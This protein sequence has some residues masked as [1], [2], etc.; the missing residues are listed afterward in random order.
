MQYPDDQN[1]E[2]GNNEDAGVSQDWTPNVQTP[3]GR[4][5]SPERQAGGEYQAG[6]GYEG[7]EGAGYAGQQGDVSE[8]HH[9]STNVHEVER[10]ASVILGAGLSLYAIKKLPLGGIAAAIGGGA[11]LYR[12]VTGHCHT[13]A[14]LGVNTAR[15]AG[16]T[17]L[18]EDPAIPLE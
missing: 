5:G 2:R 12:G 16:G 15:G 17:R 4:T 1:T 9:G 11:L 6:R 10:I 8:R 18:R 14:A 3:G 13:Y 7:Q